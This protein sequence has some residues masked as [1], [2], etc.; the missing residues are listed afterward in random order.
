MLEYCNIVLMGVLILGYADRISRMVLKK[1]SNEIELLG[2]ILSII[3][4]F[5]YLYSIAYK[6]DPECFCGI[7]CSSPINALVDI[8]LFTIQTFAIQNIIDIVPV[9]PIAKSI[10]SLQLI[11]FTVF[12]S[13]ILLGFGSF[14]KEER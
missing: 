10:C 9:N 5:I 13:L 8:I 3:S 2:V 7:N 12:I 11:V 6:I 14:I 1:K 4:L